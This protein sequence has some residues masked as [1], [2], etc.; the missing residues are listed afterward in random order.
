MFILLLDSSGS[1]KFISAVIVRRIPQISCCHIARLDKNKR[2]Y[3]IEQALKILTVECYSICVHAFI[4]QK[5][6][7]M[8]Y[9]NRKS[10]KRLWR[11]TIKSELTKIANHLKNLKFQPIII[12]YADREFY[13]YRDIIEE[14]FEAD[15]VF[16][17][18]SNRLCL[19]DVVA[20]LNLMN[21]RLLK[22]IKNF[23]EIKQA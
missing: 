3:I 13:L 19:A 17:E 22:E 10:K 16:I 21:P 2:K 12:V 1:W 20:Y 8:S 5:V 15:N 4:H 14:V 9:G 11:G 18:K 7:M 6:R 23:R